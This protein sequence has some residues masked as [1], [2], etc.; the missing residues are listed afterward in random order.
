MDIKFI[1]NNVW[2]DSFFLKAIMIN[3]HSTANNP[4]FG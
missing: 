4:T 3:D 2:L 1:L